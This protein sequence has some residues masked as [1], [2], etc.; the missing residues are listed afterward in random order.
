MKVI[1][2]IVKKVRERKNQIIAKT[3]TFLATAFVTGLTAISANAAVA[4]EITQKINGLQTDAKTVA[5]AAA[6]LMVIF[7]G[8]AFMC[9]RAGKETGK[10]WLIGIAIGCLVVSVAS[11]LVDFFKS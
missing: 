4:G 11:S 8:I 10:S 7:A 5:W 1:K 2:N 3:S 6:I 9:G